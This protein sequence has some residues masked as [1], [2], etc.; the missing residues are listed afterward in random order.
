MQSVILHAKCGFDSHESNFNTHTCERHSR[1]WFID[2]EGNFHTHCDFDKHECDHDCDKSDFYTQSLILTRICVI[3][4]LTGVIMT[5]ECDFN[6]HKIEFY[7]QSTISTRRVCFLHTRVSLTRLRVNMTL[8][9]VISTRSSEIPLHAERNFYT[10]CN[11]DRHEC[12]SNTHEFDF[13][14]HKIDFYTHI[15]ISTCKV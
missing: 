9:I 11:F 5:L 10:Q 14:T 13:N 4:T 1:V 8:S 2:A 15:T 12:D 3:M 6:T 7:T